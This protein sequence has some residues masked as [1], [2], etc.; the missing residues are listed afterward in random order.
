MHI[1]FTG[2]GIFQ[3]CEKNSFVPRIL[4]PSARIQEMVTQQQLKEE[5]SL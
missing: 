3:K 4:K 2:G 5:P 1:F